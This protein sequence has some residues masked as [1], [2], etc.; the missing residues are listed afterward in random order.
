MKLKSSIIITPLLCLCSCSA[1]TR[2]DG[3]FLLDNNF[4]IVKE[5]MGEELVETEADQWFEKLSSIL[6]V[7]KDKS[8][9]LELLF[10]DN[11]RYYFE[12]TYCLKV[13]KEGHSGSGYFLLNNR[14]VP[15]VF[16]KSYFLIFDL[17][18]EYVPNGYGTTRT[19]YFQRW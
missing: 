7:R 16:S 9:T 18:M 14:E 15:L 1:T 4:K 10:K 13:G 6:S 11:T 3:Y 8:Y 5:Y 2:I 17:P 19:L 12:G